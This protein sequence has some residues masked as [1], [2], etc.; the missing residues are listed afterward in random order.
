MKQQKVINTVQPLQASNLAFNK[1]SGQTVASNLI[2][3]QSASTALSFDAQ[4]NSEGFSP[5]Q[6]QI[7]AAN[8]QLAGK[9]G[10]LEF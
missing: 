2:E 7:T 5:L 8:P 3:N 1:A 6:K 9:L 4:S 10:H